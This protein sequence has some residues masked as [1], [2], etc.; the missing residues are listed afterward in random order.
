[1]E[2]SFQLESAIGGHHIYNTVWTPC[3]GETLSL[4]IEDENQHDS[5]AVAIVKNDDVVGHAPRNLSRVFY[6]FLSH[7][8][9]ISA[10]ITG[11]RK[12]GC[13]L[14]VPCLYTLTGKPSVLRNYWE[15]KQFHDSLDN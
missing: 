3:L 11:H 4:R 12:F 13:G 5:F 1:M 9:A 15:E 7:D 8:G 6:F 2:F 14:E 10:E